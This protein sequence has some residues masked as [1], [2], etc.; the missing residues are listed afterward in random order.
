MTKSIKI[1]RLLLFLLIA[2]WLI[3]TCCNAWRQ[4]QPLVRTPEQVMEDTLQVKPETMPNP[5]KGIE[6][7]STEWIGPPPGWNGD[8]MW[9]TSGDLTVMYHDKVVARSFGDTCLMIMDKNGLEQVKQT[10][11]RYRK[12]QLLRW[13]DSL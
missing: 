5:G 4:V 10:Y 7:K 2:A 6:F 12:K 13:R 3:Y 1:A 11:E 8:I 9:D